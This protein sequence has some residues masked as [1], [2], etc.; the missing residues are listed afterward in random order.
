[1]MPALRA[2]PQAKLESLL[3]G[4]E[5]LTG[6]R[7]DVVAWMRDAACSEIARRN[8]C[9]ALVPALPRSD[10]AIG[11][12]ALAAIVAHFKEQCEFAP[13]VAFLEAVATELGVKH[14]TS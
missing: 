8:G 7:L 6:T 12:M 2:L 13:T 9:I 10:G 5:A 1:M 4:A 3:E 11:P 14:P